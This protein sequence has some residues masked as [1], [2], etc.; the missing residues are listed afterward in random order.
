MINASY[1]IEDKDDI[2]AREIIRENT[3]GKDPEIALLDDFHDEIEMRLDQV[4]LYYPIIEVFR[5][6][7]AD[8]ALVKILPELCFL[9]LLFFIYEGKLKHRGL[10]FEEIEIFINKSMSR[11][12][13]SSEK[14]SRE[15]VRGL[16]TELLDA[17]QNDGRNFIFHVYSFKSHSFKEKYIKLLEIKQADDG[18]LQ[19]F[20]TEQGVDFFLKTKEF[21]DETKITI[22]LLL[23][24]KQM[25]KG[26]FGYAYETVRRLNMEVQKK[27]DKK[28][29][30]LEDLMYGQIDYG[31]SYSNYHKS[32]TTQ[33]EEESELFNA[34]IQNVRSAFNEYIERIN[35]NEATEKEIRIFT[36]IKIIEKEI[37]KAQT[38]HTELLKEVAGFTREYD[39]VL[40]VRR[41][42]IFSDRF[43]FQGEFDRVISQNKSPETLKFLFE[44][45]VRPKLRKSFNPLRALEPHRISKSEMDIKDEQ[46]DKEDAER[47][48]I[49]E[50][51]ANR[52]RRNFMFYA[53]NLFKAL[54]DKKQISLQEFCNIILEK[55]SEDLLYNG[56]FI[57]FIIE[58]NREKDVGS[59]KREIDYSNTQISLDGDF[60]S[61]EEIFLKAAIDAKLDGL[62]K[63]ITIESY[64]GED[65]ELLPGLK[66]TNMIF[67]GGGNG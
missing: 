59:H 29:T 56:D 2:L 14:V 22:N 7:K 34:A 6:R 50:L 26:A 11:M 60:K 40:G 28:Y 37:S 46:E 55:Y 48:T 63:K 47:V 9:L 32:V 44:P 13:P 10:T 21:P 39:R 49:D 45:L 17:L 8:D 38:L 57:S 43:S 52:V 18:S 19:Y 42:A 27:K 3:G 5:R 51:T 4:K 35:N 12:L 24:Q 36:L 58:M 61:I 23:F 54:L 62:I 66:I 67:T 31:Q 16:T 53:V 41:K 1:K 20:I 64:P 30:L 25:E 33:F 15:A 65:I